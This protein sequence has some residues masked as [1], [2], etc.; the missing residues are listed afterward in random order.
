MTLLR[1]TL[2]HVHDTG[3]VL[4]AMMLDADVVKTMLLECCKEITS[5]P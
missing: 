1:V 3:S 4:R 5:I 2:Q